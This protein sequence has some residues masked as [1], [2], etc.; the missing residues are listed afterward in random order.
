MGSP[1]GV[2][3]GCRDVIG[4]QGGEMP[5]LAWGSGSVP[6][7]VLVVRGHLVAGRF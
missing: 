6:D 2:G 3:V 4:P 7:I 1:E 5:L